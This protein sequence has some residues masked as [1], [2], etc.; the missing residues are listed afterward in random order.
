LIFWS[1]LK[2]WTLKTSSEIC[3]NDIYLDFCFLKLQWLFTNL[4][5]WLPGNLCRSRSIC[6]VVSSLLYLLFPCTVE[7][8]PRSN[9][10]HIQSVKF[11]PC[12]SNFPLIN[13]FSFWA[14]SRNFDKTFSLF[15][16]QCFAEIM[17]R[18]EVGDHWTEL[19]IQ[20]SQVQGI[21]VTGLWILSFC[22][23]QSS[24]SWMFLVGGLDFGYVG[25]SSCWSYPWVGRL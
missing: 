21:R 12:M 22:I 6:K 7:L 23:C 24:I 11:K 20:Q 10:L 16:V 15:L 5:N 25:W 2:P 18:S 14:N 19:F 4:S 13:Y 17:S 9:S 1:N 8:Y 3:S